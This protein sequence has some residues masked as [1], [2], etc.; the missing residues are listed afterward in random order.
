MERE[1]EKVSVMTDNEIRVAIA[2][3]CG[4]KLETT[5]VHDGLCWHLNGVQHEFAP[6]DYPSDLNAMHEAEKQ[7]TGAQCLQFETE[8]NTQT[9]WMKHIT[10]F[11]MVH[12]TARQRA[13]A[14][15]RAIGKWVE[16]KP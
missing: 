6:P 7:L 1:V 14:F 15:L 2:E 11:P 10:A 12:S 16:T 4:W 8:L 5:N 3:A 9:K 13:E